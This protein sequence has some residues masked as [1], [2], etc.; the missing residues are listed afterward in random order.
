[1]SYHQNRAWKGGQ[2]CSRQGR[3][4]NRGSRRPLNATAEV[5][6]MAERKAGAVLAG[7]PMKDGDPGNT[8]LPGLDDLG[9]T[10]MQSSRWQKTDEKAVTRC[11]RFAG[12]R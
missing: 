8:M 11:Y 5:K 12:I 10:K 3:A 9:I 1:M 2:G 7:L 4:R 6:L